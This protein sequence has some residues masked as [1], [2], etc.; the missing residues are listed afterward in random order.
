M[1]TNLVVGTPVSIAGWSDVRAYRVIAVSK[2]GKTAKVQRDKTTLLN[3][4]A[5][6]APDALRVYTG[7]Y[8]A[9]VEGTQ[10]WSFEPD[11][12]GAVQTISLRKGGVWGVA[13]TKTRGGPRVLVGRQVEHYD[14]NF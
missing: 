2:S 1:T 9:H 10:R 13:G 11:P 14:Y 4:P 12:S 7:G 3:G 8:A 5:S 6:G